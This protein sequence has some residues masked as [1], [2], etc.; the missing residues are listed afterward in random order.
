MR[1]LFAALLI[2]I[3]LTALFCS[4]KFIFNSNH[5]IET[6]EVKYTEEPETEKN[7]KLSIND[8]VYLGVKDYGMIGAEDKDD[9]EYRFFLNGSEITCK[10]AYDENYAIQN[11]LMEGSIYD[12]KLADGVLVSANFISDGENVLFGEYTPINERHCNIGN[13]S[14][15]I[16]DN[17]VAYEI[18]KLPGGVKLEMADLKQG[19]Y[20]MAILSEDRVIRMYKLEK[21]SEY[22]PPVQGRAGT[23]TLKNLLQTALE[24]IGTTLYVYGGGWNWQDNG[25]SKEAMTIGLPKSWVSFF[26]SQDEYYRFDNESNHAESYFPYGAWN[27]YYY[28]GADCSGYI[29]WVIYNL[30]Y[31]ADDESNKGFVCSSTKMA[32]SLSK[33]GFGIMDMG[34]TRD[35]KRYFNSKEFKPGDIFSMN[36]HC[37][38]CLG[39][40]DDG[41][42]VILHSTPKDSFG[43]GVQISA[44]GNDENCKA[45]SLAKEYMNRYYKKWNQRYGDKVLLIDIGTYT[46]VQADSLAGRF[47]WDTENYLSDPDAYSEMNAE[48]I[49]ADLFG[50]TEQ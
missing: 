40:C 16:S 43:A 24:P 7:S 30:T 26:D 28:A 8:A 33:M 4:L 18:I 10:I 38:I 37:W 42:L 44:L 12:I 32:D 17:T 20:V 34:V 46:T 35:G 31:N 41:S 14:C 21:E 19:N 49:L 25:S 45:Y 2:I 9:F 5:E 3:M 36:G 23:R 48:Q 13:K 39:K 6:E 11:N 15:S 1:K 29:G 47:S 50:E 22:I 27:Q